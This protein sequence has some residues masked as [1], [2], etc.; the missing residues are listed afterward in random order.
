MVKTKSFLWFYEIKVAPSLK[1]CVRQAIPQL[2][3]YAYWRQN[4]IVVG[5]LY[6]AA[7]FKPTK[8]VTD[9]LEL[10]R[11]RF[12]VPIYYEQIVI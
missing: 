1:A 12:S 3:E 9:Y 2:L 7:H 6:V 4:K 10:L 8:E 5:R 11:T